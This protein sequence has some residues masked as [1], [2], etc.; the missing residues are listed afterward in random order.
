MGVKQQMTMQKFFI[1]CFLMMSVFRGAAQSVEVQYDYNA[2]GDCIFGAYNNS[3]APLFLHINFADLE[4]T[5]FSEPLPYVK[6][7]NPGFT[8][9]FTLLRDPDGGVPRFNY[10][11]KVYRSDP[12]AR[13]DLE[14]PYLIPFEEGR[15]VKVFE[16]DE[17]DG[18]WG[19]EG[20]DSWSATGFYA[21][22]GDKI[23]A[24]RN[25]VVVELTGATRSGDPSGWYNTWINAITLLQPDGSLICYHNVVNSAKSMKVGDQVYAGQEIGQAAKGTDNVTVL[26]YHES[27]FTK[28]PLFV[29]PEFVVDEG[30][31]HILSSTV[32][33]NVVHPDE[34][35]GLE[36]SKKERRQILGKKR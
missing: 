16:V 35:R 7:L 2:T 20:L 3:K 26:I 23:F 17:I 25:G 36:M 34:I 32:T 1:T 22:P 18:F 29:I 8:N 9:L 19:S 13:I 5:S 10:E 31:Q 6:R 24:S 4:N 27:M 12:M 15:R 21:Q 28:Y 14:F 30:E 33:Y 11:I